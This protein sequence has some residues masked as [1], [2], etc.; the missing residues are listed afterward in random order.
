[1][2]MGQ[3]MV[4]GGIALITLGILAIILCIPIFSGQRKRLEK[5]IKEDYMA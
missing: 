2:T 3:M 4:Y 1:M 5:K